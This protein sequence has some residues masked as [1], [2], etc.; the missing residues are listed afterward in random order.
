MHDGLFEQNF[1][2]FRCGHMILPGPRILE[3]FHPLAVLGCSR[4]WQSRACVTGQN[5][6]NVSDTARMIFDQ[7]ASQIAAS[8]TF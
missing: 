4:S 8:S 7:H 1:D 2:V 6:A 5:G 3:N